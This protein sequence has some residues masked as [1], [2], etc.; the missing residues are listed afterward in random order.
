MAISSGPKSNMAVRI[1]DRASHDYEAT[2]IVGCCT[3]S[4]A[5]LRE[6]ISSA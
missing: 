5:S 1:P 6:G 2:K 4:Q 3:V